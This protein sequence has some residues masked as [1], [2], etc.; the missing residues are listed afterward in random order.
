[1]SSL[2]HYEQLI[3][4]SSLNYKVKNQFSYLLHQLK[5]AGANNKCSADV[6]LAYKSF[7]T[8]VNCL[9]DCDLIDFANEIHILATDILNRSL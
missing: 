7:M 9:S 8:Y 2:N 1:M 5:T 6:L 3:I 4:N